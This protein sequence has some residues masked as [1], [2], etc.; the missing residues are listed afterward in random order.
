MNLRLH[1]FAAHRLR[2][3]IQTVLERTGAADAVL[4]DGVGRVFHRRRRA[5]C[6]PEGDLEDF[7]EGG[8]GRQDVADGH[9]VE[10]G[11]QFAQPAT[12]F[13]CGLELR[14]PFARDVDR[15]VP[16]AGPVLE[17]VVGDLPPAARPDFI[18]ADGTLHGVGKLGDA[19][20]ICVSHPCA[21]GLW[22]YIYSRDPDGN[23]DRQILANID[24]NNPPAGATFHDC[25]N[26]PRR[27]IKSRN[28]CK[29]ERDMDWRTL[30]DKDIETLLGDYKWIVAELCRIDV[31]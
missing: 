14:E 16:S 3:R 23:L 29:L 20:R 30:S 11:E 5:G 25:S 7:F 2:G 10:L 31:L 17:F 6:A 4:R 9:L 13:N 19:G 1:Q 24:R 22:T 12:A 8:R 27:G 21:C 26:D 28:V 15:M 18:A